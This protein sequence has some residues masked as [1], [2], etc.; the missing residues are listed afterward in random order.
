MKK[1][2]ILKKEYAYLCREL[3]LEKKWVSSRLGEVQTMHERAVSAL[4]KENERLRERMI[5]MEEGLGIFKSPPDFRPRHAVCAFALDKYIADHLPFFRIALEHVP[6]MDFSTNP[7]YYRF[8]IEHNWI[9]NYCVSCD[10]MDCRGFK[11]ADGDDPESKEEAAKQWN[12][13]A[14]RKDAK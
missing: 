11:F 5:A 10:D 13:C 1:R 2:R 8:E 3:R 12:K 6:R 14:G 4:K 7:E 9:P